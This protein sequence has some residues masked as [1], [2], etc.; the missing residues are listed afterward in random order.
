MTGHP[1]DIRVI[2]SRI[3]PSEAGVA[4][5][6]HLVRRFTYRDRENWLQRIAAGELLIDGTTAAPDSLLT[7]GMTLEYRPTDIREPEVDT[8]YSICYED[9]LLLVV[10]KPGN[11]PTHPSGIFYT[12]TLW[13]LL[14]K[15]FGP[16]H[17]VNRLDRETSGLLLAAKDPRTAAKLARAVK[18]KTYLALVAGRMTEPIDADGYLIPAGSVVRKKRAFV[19]EL[20]P[21]ISGE[22]AR[23]RLEPVM[24][25]NGLSLIRATLETGRMHQ[26]RATCCSLGYP[27]AGDKLYGVDETCYLRLRHGPLPPEDLARLQMPR[28][29]LHA[30]RL[31]FIHPGH[32]GEC[33]LF[34][35][36]PPDMQDLICKS[37]MPRYI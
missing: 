25:G 21:G 8:G 13:Y 23:T 28:Q 12:H 36:L 30:A 33:D 16:I 6:D 37:G 31:R 14:T 2:R 20:P 22:T 32:G 9:D 35:P 1:L 24:T 11:L 7:A 10:D 15:R 29:A 5:I 18:E 26:I 4:L 19:R 3:R 34:S 17:L 27:L